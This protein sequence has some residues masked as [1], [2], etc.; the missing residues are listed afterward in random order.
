MHL[1]PENRVTSSGEMGRE[2]GCWGLV[3]ARPPWEAWAE[4]G[5]IGS[6]P[7]NTQELVFQ[8]LIRGLPTLLSKALPCWRGEF[9]CGVPRLPQACVSSQEPLS[10]LPALPSPIPTVILC[11]CSVAEFQALP[12]EERGGVLEFQLTHLVPRLKLFSSPV[13]RFEGEPG[14]VGR[15]GSS[16]TA[17]MS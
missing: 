10:P 5:A 13:F 15:G 16:S 8:D 11:C 4:A 6:L 1:G 17:G 2:P 9:G 3:P 7:G 14:N 12:R